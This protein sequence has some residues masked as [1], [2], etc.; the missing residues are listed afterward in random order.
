MVLCGTK[1]GSSMQGYSN[2]ARE[3]HFPAEF[4]SNPNQTHLSMLINVF[5]III[6]SQVGEFDQGWC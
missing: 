1:N 2:L 6:K 3:I 5:R 4:N